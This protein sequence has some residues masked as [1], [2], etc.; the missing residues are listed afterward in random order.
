MA[1]LRNIGE[2]WGG[3]LSA[4][5]FLA[6]FVGESEWAHID[7]AGPSFASKPLGYMGKG[8]TGMSVRTVLQL[9]EDR[10]S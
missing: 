7:I 5:V 1:D 8:A 10:A 4:G 3:A 2:R 9:L 6:E